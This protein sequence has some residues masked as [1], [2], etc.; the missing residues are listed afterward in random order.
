M[1]DMN[2]G[3][4][5]SSWLSVTRRAMMRSLFGASCAP[6]WPASSEGACRGTRFHTC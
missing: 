1:A 4:M 5:P 2:A 6:A 3:R